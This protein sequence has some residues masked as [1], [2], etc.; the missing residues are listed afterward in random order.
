MSHVILLAADRA[1]PLCPSAGRR[2][3][4]RGGVSIEYDG[5]SVEEHRY[6]RAAVEDLMLPLKPFQFELNLE[7]DAEGLRCLRV[8]LTKTCSPGEQVQLWNLWVGGPP[9]RL[10][11]FSGPLAAFDLDTLTQ[12]M[13][14]YQTCITITI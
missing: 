14:R 2:V 10:Y 11:R 8:Y 9:H 6:Y 4:S 7:A 1:L 3:R 12:L 13:E 5:F